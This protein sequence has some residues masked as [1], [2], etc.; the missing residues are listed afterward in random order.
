MKGKMSRLNK[1]SKCQ[2]QWMK[3]FLCQDTGD[4]SN[5]WDK[6]KVPREKKKSQ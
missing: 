5:A 1:L 4:M 6:Q 3:T 2:E